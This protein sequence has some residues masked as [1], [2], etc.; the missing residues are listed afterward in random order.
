[1]LSAAT[2]AYWNFLLKRS[3]GGQL[4]VGLSKVVEAG[5][6]APFLIAGI[7]AT[8]VPVRDWWALPVVGA[9][10]VLINYVMLAAAYKRAELSVV[11]P[12]SRGGMLVFLPP[13]G[14]LLMG[15]RLASLGWMALTLIIA[16]IGLM[17]LPR[18]RLSAVAEL[19]SQ[20][21]APATAYALTAAFVAAC[22]TI[23]DKRAI[24]TLSPITYFAAYTVMLG[25]AYGGVLPALVKTD[26]LLRE[27][28]IHTRVILLVATLNIGS[29]LLTLTALRT[30][31]ASYVIALRQLSIA[32]GALLGWRLLGEAVPLRGVWE[33][34]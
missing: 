30:G 14:F 12:V 34:R 24:Q 3:G 11:Y 29:Y 1:M 2:H 21:G 27:W 15:E 6:L 26:L 13:L 25:L 28:R 19:R 9:L 5:I 31:Q 4:V 17:Q 23:W 7:S 16:G 33:S 32:A 18:F 20:L 8:S 22:Y 10:L